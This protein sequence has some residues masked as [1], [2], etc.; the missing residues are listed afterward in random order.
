M[1]WYVVWA[2]T[3]RVVHV[4][5]DVRHVHRTAHRARFFSYKRLRIEF[6][7]AGSSEVA[8]ST[9]TGEKEGVDEVDVVSRHGSIYVSAF[10][11]LRTTLMY[12]ASQVCGSCEGCEEDRGIDMLQSDHRSL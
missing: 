2:Y 8:G 3:E 9:E 4:L 1:C 11:P 12:S 10:S 6:D 7:Q 5:T